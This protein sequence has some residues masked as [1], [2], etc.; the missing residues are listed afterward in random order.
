M[1]FENQDNQ[2]KGDNNIQ[3]KIEIIEHHYTLYTNMF[4]DTDNSKLRKIF[5]SYSLAAS[6]GNGLSDGKSESSHLT[7]FK[8][9]VIGHIYAQSLEIIF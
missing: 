6:G 8:R 7:D 9:E 4:E 1:S 2:Y 5:S 3:N